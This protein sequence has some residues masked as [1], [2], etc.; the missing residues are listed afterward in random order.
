M[1]NDFVNIHIIFILVYI[2]ICVYTVYSLLNESGQVVQMSSHPM[3]QSIMSP[4]LGLAR[5]G[6]ALKANIASYSE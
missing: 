6:I 3:N 1:Y 2:H 4:D 5:P